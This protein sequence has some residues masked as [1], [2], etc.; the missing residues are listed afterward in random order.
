MNKHLRTILALFLVF[1]FI[2]SYTGVRLLVHYCFHCDVAEYNMFVEPGHNC[3]D[4]EHKHHNND[5]I[6]ATCCSAVGDYDLNLQHEENCENCC[7]TQAKYFKNDYQTFKDNAGVRILLP[8]FAVLPV[9][10]TVCCA[11]CTEEELF[12]DYIDKPPRILTGK[13]FVIFTHQLKIC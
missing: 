3:C 4:I 10:K 8:V 1:N 2:V 11:T 7:S 12:S 9:L 6:E 13:E 5:D